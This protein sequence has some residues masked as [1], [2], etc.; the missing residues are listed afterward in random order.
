[1][2]PDERDEAGSLELGSETAIASTLHDL[3][4]L[5][6]ARTDRNDQASPVSKLLDKTARRNV[7]HKNAAS[8]KKSRLAKLLNRCRAPVSYT[9][10][11]LP[12]T[13]VVCISRWAPEH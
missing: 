2:P 9:H 11:T 3:E 4:H 1:M 6:F 5:G 13:D 12:T 10:L 7:I 8:R